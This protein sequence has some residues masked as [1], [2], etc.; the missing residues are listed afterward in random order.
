MKTFFNTKL[1]RYLSVV[2]ATTILLINLSSVALAESGKNIV[3]GRLFEFDKDSEYGFSSST[4]SKP[5]DAQNTYGEFSVSGNV[6]EVFSKNGIP[7]YQ[8]DSGSLTLTYSYGDKLLKAGEDEWHLVEDKSKKVD[9]LSLEGKILKGAIIIQTSK[10]QKNWVTVGIGT[11][12]FETTPVNTDSMYTTQDIQLTNGCFYRVTVAYELARK[13][14]ESNFLFINTDKYEYKKCSEVYDFYACTSSTV[15]EGTNTNQKFNLGSA[16]RCEHFKGYDG[17]KAIEKGDPHY[18][19]SLGQFFVSGYTDT[20]VDKENNQVFLKNVGDKVTLWF[21][22]K[23]NINA[24]GGNAKV[25]VTADDK[26]Y[27]Q[28]F[29]TTPT[30]FGRG[31]LIIRFTDYNNISSTPQ[32]YTNYLEANTSVG[33]DTKVSLFEEG[34]YEVALDYEVTEDKLIDSEGHYRIFFKFSIRNGNCM[35]YPFDLKT[36]DELTNSA[37]TE[38]GFR[39]DLA[40][41]RYLKVVVK[42]EVMAESADGLVEDTCFNGPAKDGAEYKDEGI[43]TIT[44]TNQYTNQLTV[45]KIYV[46]TNS[47]LRAYMTTGLSIKEI[48]NLVDNGATIN[49]DGSIKMTATDRQPLITSTLNEISN[50][51]AEN[52][53]DG[54]PKG[55]LISLIIAVVLISG[56]VCLIVFKKKKTNIIVPVNEANN[57]AGNTTT[58][59]NGGNQE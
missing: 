45:K 39:L 26:G 3:T 5:T 54:F 52:A 12:V 32:I 18:G 59:S 47:I 22:L 27:D 24:I 36:G 19:I 51:E 1:I 29:Q 14:E 44:V 4:E 42:R 15:Q 9:L 41:S 38:N 53:N 57:N 30:D 55:I 49:A 31:T 35:I 6:T 46:G 58:E 7:A 33:A 13:T 23:E 28:Y 2:L 17:E 8:V 43:Y 10:D 21:N 16:V 56:F 37:M 34:D 40:K 48:N 20:A 50:D 25:T 11:N